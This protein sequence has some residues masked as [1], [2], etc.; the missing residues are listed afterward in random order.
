MW[1]KI[2]S[3][4]VTIYKNAKLLGLLPKTDKDF[5]KEYGEHLTLHDFSR[6][7]MQSKLG[8]KWADYIVVTII[9]I[10]LFLLLA[11][12]INIHLII[13][14]VLM[15]IAPLIVILFFFLWTLTNIVIDV[16]C[17]NAV[18]DYLIEKMNACIERAKKLEKEIK[19]N[20]E[21]L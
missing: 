10:E 20:E 4:L 17:S 7:R 18:V 3:K 19:E 14:I 9:T 21:K 12:N 5:L 1:K 16:N 13:P 6:I 2:K 8:K 15:L 11:D